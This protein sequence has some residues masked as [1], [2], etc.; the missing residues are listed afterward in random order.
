MKTAII[1]GYTLAMTPFAHATTLGTQVDNIATVSYS[2]GASTIIAQTPPASF[3]IEAQRTPSTIE[4]FRISPNAPDAISV[5]I[6]G[7]D[8]S[9]SGG[10]TPSDFTPVGTVSSPGGTTVDFSAPQPLAPATN[11]FAGEIIFVSVTDLGQNGNPAQ[12]ETLVATI[13]AGNGD[14]ITLRL[15]ESGPD[16]G[17]FFAYT[18][19]LSGSILAND[20]ALSIEHDFPLVATYQDPFVAEDISTD[21]AGVDPFGRLFDSATGELINGAVVT[22]VNDATGL[23]APVFGIDGFSEYPSTVVTGSVVTDASGLVYDL[24]DGEFR[25]P[26]MFPGTYRLVIEPPAGFTAPSAAPRDSFD[27]LPNAPFI[28]IDASFGGSFLLDGTGDVSFDVPLDSQTEVIIRK[29][30][31]VQTGAVGDFV[32]YTIEIENT[33]DSATPAFIADD[34]PTGFRYQAGTAHLDG[35]LIGEPIISASGTS[36]QFDVGLIG[37]QQIAELTYIVEIAAGAQLGE[38]VNAAIAVNGSGAALS[39]RAE[40][41]IYIQEDLLRSRLT[42]VGRV[43]EDACDP[44]Q[45]WPRKISSGKGVAG[46][47]LYM[48]TG[49]YVVTDQDGLFHFEDIEARSH[50]VQLDEITIPEGYELVQCEDNTRFAGSPYSQF[51]DAQGGSVW[52]ANFYLKNNNPDKGQTSTQ[53]TQSQATEYLQYDID[54]LNKQKLELAWAYPAADATPTSR[55]VNIGLKHDITHSVHL[56]LNDNK[57]PSVNF[58]G[59]DVNADRTIALSR[60]RGLGLRDGENRFEAILFDQQ[61]NEISRTTRVL[62]FINDALNAEYRENVSRL[63]ADGT[64]PPAI[65]VRLT[66]NAGRPVHKG[67][68]VKIAIDPPYRAKSLG[69]IEDLAPIDAALSTKASVSV[70]DNG[71]AMVELEPTLNAGKAHIEILLDDGRRERISALLKPQLR[72]WIVVGLAEGHGALEKTTTND[73]PSARDALGNGRIAV[74]AKGV[75]K[76]DWLVTI[77]ADTSKGRGDLDDELFDVIDPDAR[78]PLYGDR[79][80]QEFEAQSRYPVYAKVEK[81]GFQGLFGDYNTGLS[82]ARLGRYSRR[83]SGLKADYETDRFSLNAFAAETNQDFIKDEFAADGTS[84]PFR[85]SVTPI[86]RNSE[87]IIIE[88][89][90]RFRPDQIINT[91]TLARYTDYDIDFFTGELVF[92]LP[93]PA[94][95]GPDTINVIVADYETAEVVER[96]LTV[97]GRAAVRALD[98][99]VELGGTLVHEEGRANAPGG[100]SDLAA[101][102]FHGKINDK[103]EI[104]LEYGISRRD[105]DGIEESGDAIIAE[106]THRSENLTASAYFNE[107]DENFGL[108]QQSSGT[109]GVRR[110]GAEANFR[111]SSGAVENSTQVSERFVEASAYREENLE[112]G[113]ERTVSEVALRQEGPFT[114]GSI[115]LRRVVEKPDDASTR[116]SLL[117]TS[118]IRQNFDKV[119]LTIH[120]SRDQPITSDGDSTFFPKRTR[121]GLDQRITKGLSLNVSHEI[122]DGENA[123]S[124]NTIVG[125]TANPWTGSSITAATDIITQDAGRNIGATLGVDQ[126]VI[127]NK[128]WSGSFG[129][130]RRQQLASDGTIDPLEDIVPD[131]AISPLEVDQDFTSI[132]VGAGYRDQVTNGSA[133]VEVRQSDLG[134]R[135]TYVAGAAREVS[136]QLSFAGAARVEDQDN[137][138]EPDSRS[139]DARLGAAWRPR[140]ATG[141]IAFNRFDIKSEQTA[142]EFKSWKVVNNLALNAL[143]DER[144]QVSLNHGFKYS[145]IEADGLANNGVTQLFGTEARVDITKNVDI[146]VQG[147]AL[148]SHNSGTVEYSYGPSIGIS[149]AKNIWISAG[150]NFEGFS[151]EDFAAAE[152]TNKGPFI[153]LRIKFD[154]NTAKGLLEKISPGTSN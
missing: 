78:F 23:P 68:I 11:F 38:A 37:G 7:S 136:E 52:R 100:K 24:E 21:V 30:A 108:N 124:A 127:L 54:W 154:Q 27:N 110:F 83:L 120:A 28:I 129:L 89:R 32:R 60:W 63:I 118:E 9:P 88:T 106:I 31:S 72:D 42:I 96:D 79:S 140:N 137:E 146:G 53:A 142:G 103:T 57:V 95:I 74:F 128:N 105:T 116:K 91:T 77:A 49:A 117:A 133:R 22:I 75:V 86:V 109:A 130:T 50:V 15:Y 67:R 149:P 104:H 62:M 19:S 107:T 153:K 13:D 17:Q 87:T 81:G 46:V 102:D 6:N 48:E 51:V 101:V 18:Q 35:A 40:A 139:I 84:G 70:G 119:G 125:I 148:Y 121:V 93:V 25:F 45:D 5:L 80:I 36:L 150:W 76:E 134:Q 132:Y 59:R 1:A 39:N 111:L 94:A 20:E 14:L 114:S 151:D 147:S 73:A 123:S 64:T 97:G 115:G 56:F 141:L 8:F 65:A 55:S 34:M 131:A 43:V 26:I 138:I 16:T 112:T 3:I 135:Y 69:R 143:I 29:S 98:G 12:I 58:S 126:Q 61:G 66:D 85:L 47:R 113:A 41:A 152:F 99:R 44:A 71:I 92:R 4:F 122:Q 90:D 10:E 82:E 144:V 145:S 2:N 33:S